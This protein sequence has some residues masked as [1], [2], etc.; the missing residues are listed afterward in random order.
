MADTLP[1]DVNSSCYDCI[2]AYRLSWVLGVDEIGALLGLVGGREG[3][4]AWLGREREREG[5]EMFARRR[6]SR[7]SGS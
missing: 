4:G 1:G 6:S 5:E 2:Y 3:E 7:Y